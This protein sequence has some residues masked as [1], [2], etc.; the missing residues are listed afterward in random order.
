MEGRKDDRARPRLDT[1][2]FSLDEFLTR[3]GAVLGEFPV[4]YWRAEDYVSANL[5]EHRG[6]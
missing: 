4:A 6:S 1:G 2:S 5:I 3:F